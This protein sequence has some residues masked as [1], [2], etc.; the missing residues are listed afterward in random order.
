MNIYEDYANYIDDCS[1]I[2]QIM[3]DHASPLLLIINDVMEVTEYIYHKYNKKEKLNEDLEE[4]F[5]LGFSYLS[6]VLSDIKTY[7]EEC[8]DKNID[9]LNKYASVII[10]IVMLNDF[11]D[12][13]DVEESLNDDVKKEIENM[14]YKLDGIVSN[15]KSFDSDIITDA[16]Y[17]ID[18]YLPK[19]LDFKPVYMVF[20]LIKEELELN[21]E[22]L[23]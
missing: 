14:V 1:E 22:T 3:N 9:L 21:N 10:S 19:N 5:S 18:S 13:L 17:M 6:G 4:I 16:E 12:Y 11:I 8:L 15:Q 20:A 23:S 7:Y 2:I